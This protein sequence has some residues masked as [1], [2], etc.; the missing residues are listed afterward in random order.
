MS[1]F[2]VETYRMPAA[3]LGPENPLPPLAAL[4]FEFPWLLK[5]RQAL[6]GIPVAQRAHSA[7]TG[8][9]PHRLQDGF[10]RNRHSRDFQAI[11]LENQV[12]KAT[13]LPEIGGRLWSLIHKPTSRELLYVN[14]VYQPCNLAL[15][16]AWFSGGV[17]WNCGMIGHT[18]YT[19]S[20]IH[21][22]RVE[23]QDGM[24]SLRLYEWCRIRGVIYQMDFYLP[25]DSA[26]LLARMRVI[27]PH[28]FA[29]PMY[30]WSNVSVPETK[31][32]RIVAPAEEVWTHNYAAGTVSRTILRPELTYAI[33]R[34]QGVGDAFFVVEQHRRPFIAGL[35]AQGAGLVQASTA[36][37][38][39]RKVFVWGHNRGA[40]RWQEYLSIKGHPYIEI[41]AGLAPTQA[42]Y[43]NMPA[44]A[45]WSWLEAYG[46]AQ[47][48]PAQATHEQYS[49]AYGAVDAYL[50]RH[51]PSVWLEAE[52]IRTEKLADAEPAETINPGQPWG[53]LEARRR[54][55]AGRQPFNPP[56]LPF[57]PQRTS[58]ETAHWQALLDKGEMPYREPSR[59]PGWYMTQWDWAV[60]LEQALQAGRGKHWLSYLHLGVMYYRGEELDK[61]RAAWEQS[62]ACEES[63]WAYRCLALLAKEQGRPADAADLYAKAIELKPD[64]WQLAMECCQAQI[65]AGRS[66]VAIDLLGKLDR[67]IS[68]RPRLR[69]VE[70][71]AALELDEFDRVEAILMDV[72]LT[73]IREGEFGLTDLWFSLCEKRIAKAEGIA[74]DDALRQRVRSECPPPE[75]IDFRSWITPPPGSKT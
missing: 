39:G 46:L 42:D 57:D 15:R 17:E 1:E 21:A 59:E 54:K 63:A 36:R 8:V 40:Q 37:L 64:I 32:L 41:Q 5:A 72:E 26:W 27:N 30:W 74:I 73:D 68:Q 43:L 51:L 35:D 67:A 12:L 13:F 24:A 56:A 6:K 11:V 18:P 10:D 20:P 14:P 31:D 50:G 34:G 23:A 22:A 44:G 2:R 71:L 7:A 49:T 75:K 29:V 69:L 52:L 3:D 33:N 25:D 19:C 62:I 48:D 9:L 60:L 66:K 70:A 28:D 53:H 58:P 38:R 65:D 47:I 16:S 61:A 45:Q 55:V 4:R